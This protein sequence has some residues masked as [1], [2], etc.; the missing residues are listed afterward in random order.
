MHLPPQQSPGGRFQHRHQSWVQEPGDQR[1]VAPVD[2][3]AVGLLR[4]GH[5]LE[6]RLLACGDRAVQLRQDPVRCPLEDVD[7]CGRLRDLGHELHGTG[8]RA[9]DRDPLTRQVDRVIP[10]GGVECFSPKRLSSGE[11]GNAGFVQRPRARDDDPRVEHGTRAGLDPP[12]VRGLVEVVGDH[13]GTEPKVGRQVVVA[14][15]ALDVVENLGLPRV[16]PGPFPVGRE[17]ERVHQRHHVTAAPRIRVLPP[18]SAHAIG[19]LEDDEVFLPRL[20]QLD[21]HAQS[22]ESG[23]DDEDVRLG[24]FVGHRNPPRRHSAREVARMRPFSSRNA[25]SDSNPRR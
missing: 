17:G 10:F 15:H 8:S 4:A 22:G 9:D 18:R 2:R 21:R 7:V 23:T 1:F 14:D 25:A 19:L 5:S 6:H 3:A 11:R 20:L 16:H 24:E 12:P 13:L